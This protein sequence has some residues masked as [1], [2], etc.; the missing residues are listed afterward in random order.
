MAA[1]KPV[2]QGRWPSKVQRSL[3]LEGEPAAREKAEASAREKAVAELAELLEKAGAPILAQASRSADPDGLMLRCAGGRR[4]R[5]VRGDVVEARARLGDGGEAVWEGRRR[6]ER[7]QPKPGADGG[8]HACAGHQAAPHGS[9]AALR[10]AHL[11][12]V[13]C[14]LYG[15][16]ARPSGI[17]IGP[18][19]ST[20]L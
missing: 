13:R 3:A 1:F 10:G 20:E 15:P 9:A 18:T 12:R 6:E 8:Q 4:L 11:R 7:P 2:A 14:F 19:L 16:R 5:T 17:K